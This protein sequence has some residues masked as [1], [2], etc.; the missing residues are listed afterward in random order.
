MN[1]VPRWS[2]KWRLSIAVEKSA[3]SIA[4]VEPL[5]PAPVIT[6]VIGA[7]VGDPTQVR[8]VDS[9]LQAATVSTVTTPMASA[10]TD[11][12]LTGR[13][14]PAASVGIRPGGCMGLYPHVMQF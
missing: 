8:E 7:V 1:E 3:G 9:L 11:K 4:A 5:A 6:V 12:N 14:F 2:G 10:H 13:S